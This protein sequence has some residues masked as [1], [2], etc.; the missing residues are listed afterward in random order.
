MRL[1]TA[2]ILDIEGAIFAA[3]GGDH[4]LAVTGSGQAY[5]WGFSA[6]HQTGQGTTDD[7]EVATL[8]DNTAIRGKSLNWVGAGDQYSILTAPLERAVVNG[9]GH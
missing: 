8:I 4:S 9:T 2:A 6:S 3:G 5:S 1:L 7:I